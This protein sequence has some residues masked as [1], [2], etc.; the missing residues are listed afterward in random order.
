METQISKFDLIL[1]SLSFTLI[2]VTS[3][4]LEPQVPENRVS[5]PENLLN[6]ENRKMITED[7]G[8]EVIP[9]LQKC[10]IDIIH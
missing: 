10:E 3:Q 6:P 1:L 4:P 8:N 2:R 9:P 5:G 7:L